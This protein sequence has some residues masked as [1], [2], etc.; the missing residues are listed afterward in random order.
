MAPS[1]ELEQ[2]IDRIPAQLGQSGVDAFGFDPQYLKKVFGLAVWFYR[3]YFRAQAFGIEN[4]PDG[5]CFIVANHS[6]QLP[7]DAAMLTVAAFV[8][9]EPPRYLRAMLDR[10]I[11]S[12]PFVSVF[13][14]RCG[15]ILGTQENCKR[16]LEAQEAILVFPEG[17]KGLNKTWDARYQLQRFGSGF[18]RLA[19][20]TNTPIIPTI[21]IGAEEQAPAFANLEWVGK[22]LGIPALPVTPFHPLI[23]GLGLF[24]MPTRYRIYFGK[25][26]NF[27]GDANDDDTII[28]E[29]VEQVKQTMQQMITAGLSQREHVFW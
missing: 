25:P 9:R 23:P 16:L 20:E 10:F 3:S 26:L 11:P 18:I 1:A 28:S 19:L 6:G 29:K 24:P 22:L 21:V 2:R 4:I 17:V 13:L 27:S 8:E 7:F 15:Q 12:T 5:R 14:A